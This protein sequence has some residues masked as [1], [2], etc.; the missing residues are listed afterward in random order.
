M[1]KNLLESTCSYNPDGFGM[2][3]YDPLN[4]EIKQFKLFN[5]DNDPDVIYPILEGMHDIPCFLHFRYKTKGLINEASC[6]PFTAYDQNDRKVLLMHNGTLHEYGSNTKVD[7]EE[8]AEDFVGPLYD[9]WLLSGCRQPLSDKFFQ[10]IAQKHIGFDS[11]IALMDNTGDSVIFNYQ[12]GDVKKEAD[13]TEWWVS[14][15]YS[16]NS[17]RYQNQN[18]GKSFYSYDNQSWGRGTSTSSVVP[19]RENPQNSST[20]GQKP[21][22]ELGGKSTQSQDTIIEKEKSVGKVPLRTM[23]QSYWQDILKLDRIDELSS[24]TNDHISDL[25]DLEPEHAKLLIADLLIELFEV[26]FD[27]SEPEEDEEGRGE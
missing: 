23:T 25:V 21:S 16:F 10:K 12:K 27:G 20:D 9:K 6:H 8:F 2:M 7:S 14:N 26:P 22:N 24:M 13:G 1:P 18:T 15:S 5:G 19:F 4:K 17:S 3:F 11:K